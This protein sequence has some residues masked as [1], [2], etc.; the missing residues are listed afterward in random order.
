MPLS[1]PTIDAWARI[2]GEEIRAH[3]AQALMLLDRTL[4]YP[5]DDDSEEDQ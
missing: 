2:T 1:F 5:S 4:L 3:E